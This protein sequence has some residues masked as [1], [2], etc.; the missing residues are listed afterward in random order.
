MKYLLIIHA[1]YEPDNFFSFEEKS[2]ETATARFEEY[3][4]HNAELS[5]QY[6]CKIDKLHHNFPRYH[7]NPYNEKEHKDHYAALWE[8]DAILRDECRAKRV[9]FYGHDIT[10]YD[11]NW[12]I[13]ELEQFYKDYLA[14]TS[15]E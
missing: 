4:Q 12:E 6:Q 2:L 3:R 11:D 13:I 7:F 1:D 9:L 15:Y 5:K 10:V 14:T 8:Q